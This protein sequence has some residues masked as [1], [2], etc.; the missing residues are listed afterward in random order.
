[1]RHDALM[2]SGRLP[3]PL[4]RERPIDVV[5]EAAGRPRAAPP[6]RTWDS[7]LTGYQT[8]R[9][10][11]FRAQACEVIVDHAR[12]IQVLEGHSIGRRTR[13]RSPADD[14]AADAEEQPFGAGRVDHV[15]AA[16]IHLPEDRLPRHPR[17][18]QLA[19]LRARTGRAP[20]SP[21]RAHRTCAQRLELLAQL[22]EHLRRPE[23]RIVRVVPHEQ[24][25]ERRGQRRIR[26]IVTPRANCPS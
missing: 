22:V 25:R 1:M 14:Q 18:Y 5:E 24:D 8:R 15:I 10:H 20:M 12:V 21:V 19:D 17:R 23:A 2:R 6:P 7:R 13:A 16:A 3:S 9:A 4:E 11:D 26:A